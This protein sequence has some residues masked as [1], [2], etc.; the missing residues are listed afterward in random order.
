MNHDE[1]LMIEDLEM[2]EVNRYSS[3]LERRLV[4]TVY[5]FDSQS[6][7]GVVSPLPV[8]RSADNLV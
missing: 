8:Q 7:P 1:E 6:R 4:N 5:K 3:L 2:F